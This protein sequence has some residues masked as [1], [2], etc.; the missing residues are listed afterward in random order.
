[1]CRRLQ[2]D[3][4]LVAR[5][6]FTLIE[7]LVVIAIIA[8]LAALLL[9]ALSNAKFHAKVISCTSQYR[10]WG[11]VANVYSADN[12][13]YLPSFRLDVSSIGLNVWGVS[14]AV[15]NGLKASGL[16]VPMWFC[17]V[18]ASEYDAA[19][20][21]CATHLG[22]PLSSIADLTA[23]LS[24]TFG[25]FALM[26]HNWWVPRPE[27]D[28]TVFPDP[29]NGTGTARL[30]DGWPTKTTDKNVSVNPIISDLTDCAMVTTDPGNIPQSNGSIGGAFTT[31][32][33]HFFNGK[34]VSVNTAYAD[35][36]VVTVPRPRIQW[37]WQTGPWTEFY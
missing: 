16:T 7:L 9:P 8:I 1:M 25:N 20:K 35:G 3:L 13:D 24:A 4:G 2:R 14:T 21:W 15:P 19:S 10:Q 29:K 32:N 33:A 34:L 6:G 31:G 12:K 18:R 37:E 26:N 22:H 36:H 27:S 30:P 28:G 11:I 5:R 23:Y 17:P